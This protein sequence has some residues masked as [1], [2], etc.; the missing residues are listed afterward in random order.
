VQ[1]SGKTKNV[2][3]NFRSRGRGQSRSPNISK[4]TKGLKKTLKVEFSNAKRKKEKLN[5]TAYCKMGCFNPFCTV[6]C[7]VYFAA[8][9]LELMVPMIT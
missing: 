5:H 1:L 2:L 4:K 8:A 9:F 6:S 3:G 7:G